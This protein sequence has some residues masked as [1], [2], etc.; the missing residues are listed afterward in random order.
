MSYIS[1][2]I[3]KNND[4]VI[5]W[6]RDNDGH[7]IEKIYPAPWFFYVDDDEGDHETIYGD[8]VTKIEFKTGQQYYNA[9]KRCT[10]KNIRMWESDVS[11]DIR[12]LSEHYFNK[13]APKLHVTMFDIEVA[14]DI[15]RGFSSISNPYAPINAISMFHEHQNHM[16]E[17]CV[18]PNDG[19]VWTSEKL[20]DACNAILP[21]PSE[22]TITYHI[23]AD[24]RELLTLFLKEIEDS[25][26][27]CGWNSSFFDTPYVGKRIEIA[28]GKNA[29]RGMSFPGAKMPEF[30]EVEV[31]KQLRQTLNLSGRL[32]ADF[33]ELYKKYE[34]AKQ[35][36]YKLSSIS[37]V[38]LVD[39]IT[40]ASLLPKLEYEGTLA[41][42]YVQDFAFFIRY[43]IRD[44][45]ILHGFEQR[46]GYV[47][48][49]NQM[50]HLSTGQYQHVMGTL[51]LAELAI[52]NYCHHNINKIVNNSKHPDIDRQIDGAYV[53]LP[54]IGMHDWIGSIDVK[55][56][57]PS[58]IMSANISPET[59]RGQFT[60]TTKDAAEIALRT[61]T[62]C[63][64]EF[65]S[66]ETVIK[67]A[68]D[69]NAYLKE[70]IMAISGYGSVFS[71]SKMGIIP[72]VIAEWFATRKRYQSL[73]V[74]AEK[75]ALTAENAGAKNKYLEEAA[76]FD[77]LQYVYKIKLNSLY[78]ALSNLY[79][80][81]Y[82]LR[83]GESTTATGRAI[84]IH[85]ARKV[86]EILDGNYN[87][88]FPTYE[89]VKDAEEEGHPAETA[90]HGPKFQGKFMSESI[91]GGDTDSA[92][93]KTH[94]TCKEDAI[95]VANA[96]ADKVNES[97][98]PFM[99][100]TFLCSPGYD[101]LI[102]TSRET[103]SDK[104]I[105]ILKK[106]YV[107]HLVDLDGKAVDKMKVMGI[108]TKKTTLPKAIA[109]TLNKFIGRLLTGDEWDNI[110]QDVVTYRERLLNSPNILDLGLPKG[111]NGVE[112]YTAAY[113]L[114]KK[115]RIPGHV[116]ASI[117]FNECLQLYN[118]K[119]STP[120]MSGMKIKV[121]YVVGKCG[122]F[123][124]IAL[125]TDI[126]IVPQWFL[127]NFV[128]D[129]NAH[130][131]RLVDNPIKGVL[132]AIGRAVPTKQS[133]VFDSIFE[134]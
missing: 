5:V 66:G 36:S 45:E 87:V 30:K 123:N 118:D 40:G 82:D 85:Q 111:V 115:T 35:P 119:V 105:F 39:E 131:E 18:P 11:A 42:L 44:S 15:E 2:L 80:R 83:L 69:W 124:S 86:T 58:A 16:V 78:G 91:I 47:D 94:T 41:S 26:L 33:M 43:N 127:D 64:L 96:I 51:K 29:L 59:I 97:Y 88:D 112:S 110:A 101:T 130:M 20:R 19:N 1:A 90:L 128:V 89:T 37:D 21:I 114:D 49:S 67:S 14:Y 98:P 132:N 73:K 46:L 28:L 74:G 133:I 134:F 126:E 65:D 75:N 3:S 13:P 77:R 50:Y 56:L 61:L 122:R 52:V 106:H 95:K 38:V 129:R 17:I 99:R 71:Q 104:G 9:R 54:Q 48:V 6:E 108:A 72:A 24:E 116:G 34:Q 100:E 120:I 117:A 22:Y 79:F 84:I 23:C 107:L 102:K 76:Y 113:A 93:F 53:L 125:P 70:N 121:F 60:N 81:F 92:Y 109:D 68:Q 4:D 10:E 27:I 55:S 7:R 62:L 32:A 25:D 103:I 31:M 12:I 63:T 8:R 57:Y